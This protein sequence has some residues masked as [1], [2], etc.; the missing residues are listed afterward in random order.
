MRL[1]LA[2]GAFIILLVHG[3][4]FYKQFFHKWESYQ[5]AYF[6][7]ARGL[8]RLPGK[9]KL[10][11]EMAHDL[12]PEEIERIPRHPIR[13]REGLGQNEGQGKGPGFGIL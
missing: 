8:A 13:A 3:A 2:I 10:A 1:A 11:T 12:S 7:Q 4:V 6:D 5:T 9:A